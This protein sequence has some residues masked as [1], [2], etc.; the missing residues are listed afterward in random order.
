MDY[1]NPVSRGGDGVFLFEYPDETC[2]LYWLRVLE[3]KIMLL[4]TRNFWAFIY[5]SVLK[6][7]L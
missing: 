1:K 6:G 3:R 5:V 7:N 2:K 4:N